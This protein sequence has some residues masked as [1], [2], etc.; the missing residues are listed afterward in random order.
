MRQIGRQRVAA[1][2]HKNIAM[3]S[4]KVTLLSAIPKLPVTNL[5]ACGG[6]NSSI[7]LFKETVALFP[8]FT[9]MGIIFVS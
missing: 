6:E 9:S 5:I 8:D 3:Y 1:S 2:I 7:N 4:G